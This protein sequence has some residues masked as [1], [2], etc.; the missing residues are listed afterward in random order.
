MKKTT[1]PSKA[2]LTLA[3]SL[4]F[5]A[6]NYIPKGG[7]SFSLF[8]VEILSGLTVALALVPEAIAFAFVAGVAPLSGLY[9]AFIVGLITAV[10]GGRPGM[11]SGATGALAVVMVSLVTE[12]GA[13]Y[14]FATV[15]LMGILQLLAGIFKLGKFIRMVPEPVMLGF[16]NGLAIVI[17]ISQLSQFKTINDL[18]QSVWISGDILLYSILFV[19][20][21]MF[22]IWFLPKITKVVPSTLVAILLASVKG[23]LPNF[24]IP[25]VPLNFETLKI[26]FPY[27]FILASIGLIESL[28]TLN[29]VGEITNKRG[30]ASQECLAQGFANSVTGFFGGMGGC[31]MIGQSMINVRS[32]GRTR[33]AGIAAAVFLLIFILYTSNYIEMIPIAAL[34]GVMF[35]VVI[36]TFAW[37]SIKFLMMVPKSDALVTVL[38]TVVTVI[39]DLAVAVIVGVIVSALVYAW[40]TASRIRAIERPS[41]TDKGAKV[42]EIEGPLFFS[43]ANSFLEI[44]NPEQDPK[45][46]IIDFAKSRVIDQSALKAI[47]DVAHK[48][49]SFGKKIKL[50]HLTKDCHKILSKTGQLVVDSDNDPDYSLAVDYGVK[51]KIFGK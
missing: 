39:E 29:L 8:K 47:E 27:A 5:N 30:G 7:V 34:V 38:V 25:N 31:A 36:G 10:F 46:V 48:Y 9:A 41:K 13:E 51:L 42:Y 44:F 6:Q 24:S 32:G 15:V 4:S 3:K 18:G 19:L 49:N 43:S 37:N 22:V 17:A 21:T 50:R 26:I 11:I 1:P 35:M 14:L 12:H 16:V 2:M 40:K 28:L 33:L 20:L 45:L 23:G